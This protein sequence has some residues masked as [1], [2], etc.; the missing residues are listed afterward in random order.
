VAPD[1][2]ELFRLSH[3]AGDWLARWE[4]WQR[5]LSAENRQREL[6]DY[7]NADAEARAAQQD[8]GEQFRS[9]SRSL[10][11]LAEVA[12]Q[13]AAEVRHATQVAR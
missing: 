7:L 2:G 3:L 11:R 5:V 10:E 6:R 13:L 1:I 4:Q 9:V 12:H 8:R